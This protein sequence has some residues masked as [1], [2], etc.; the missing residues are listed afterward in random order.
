MNVND[1]GT[2]IDLIKEF[3]NSE[4]TATDFKAKYLRYFKASTKAWGEGEYEVLNTLFLD[5]DE[6]CANPSLR[7]SKDLDEPEIRARSKNALKKLIALN[8]AFT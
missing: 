6:F 2:Y 3:L 8:G 7:D 5:L 1:L 4:I